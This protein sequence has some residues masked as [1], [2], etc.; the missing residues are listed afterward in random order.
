MKQDLR[1]GG[2]L[3]QDLQFQEHR[4]TDHDFRALSRKVETLT[5][6][7]IQPFKKQMVY[8]RLTRRLKALRLTDFSDYV[9]HLDSP[10]GA[11]ELEKFVN[12][13]T[14][15][16]TSFF[17]ERHH[18]DH[19]ERTLGG[20]SDNRNSV[21]IWSAGCSAGQEIYSASVV[22][23]N[24]PCPEFGAKYLATDIDTLVLKTARRGVYPGNSIAEVPTRFRHFFTMEDEALAVEKELVDQVS[25][26]R[27]NLL[28]KWPFDWKFDYIFCRNV[29][30]YFDQSRKRAIVEKLAERLV[31]GGFLY[32]GHSE[33]LSE[34][35]KGLEPRGSTIYERTE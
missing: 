6:I 24:L 5:G 1:P 21:R 15:N 27:L 16:T 32:L 33:S 17:R 11:R 14:T 3:T 28:E 8:S 9:S 30:I 35:I 19:L 34:R 23:T 25:F 18:F 29:L 2:S 13:V 20:R 10:D 26:K 22:V 7:V 12:A 4:F 31:P